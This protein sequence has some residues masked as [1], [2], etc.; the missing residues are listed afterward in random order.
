[1]HP[2]AEELISQLNL[3][4]HPE[5]GYFKETFRSV[6]A[7]VSGKSARSA[8]TAIYFLLPA[9]QMSR[10]HSV[11]ADEVWHY[12]EGGLI[13]LWI[14]DPECKR[15]ERRQLGPL[16]EGATPQIVVPSG[17]WQAAR[18]MGAYS[19]VGCTV[20]PGFEFADFR[21]LSGDPA[22]VEKVRQRQ[23]DLVIFI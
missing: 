9:A 7:V 8:S 11:T 5:G 12:Y 2:R 13:E 10:W 17:Y 6:T 15:A 18:S 3:Q 20:A 16:R 23:T 22:Q 14:M 21:M 1:M 19:L 4:P